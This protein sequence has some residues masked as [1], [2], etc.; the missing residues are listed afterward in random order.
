MKNFNM[1]KAFLLLAATGLTVG[2]V[3]AAEIEASLTF[4][5]LPEIT[6]SEIRAVSFGSVL[7]L[8]NGAL[9]DMDT[10]TGTETLTDAQAGSDDG[11][12]AGTL[13]G[14]CD[15]SVNGTV[16]IY[17]ITSF[18]GADIT[19]T[20]SAGTASEIDF[21]PDGHVIDYSTGDGTATAAAVDTDVDVTAS[22]TG[23]TEVA[24]GDILTAKNRVL[25][26]GTIQNTQALTADESYTATFNIDVVYQ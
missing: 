16:G 22:A 12:T 17:E 4:T 5:T 6:I 11:I 18:A 9:C 15:T 7:S 25:V 23:D 10:A 19:V 24:A 20:L 8:T 21:T 13:T 2:S 1:K 3:K 26:G 14:A